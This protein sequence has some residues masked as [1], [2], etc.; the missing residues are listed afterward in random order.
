MVPYECMICKMSCIG[1]ISFIH[2]LNDTQSQE[3]EEF[4]WVLVVEYQ[5]QSGSRIVSD[6]YNRTWLASMALN[7]LADINVINVN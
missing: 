1:A 7:S 2:I 5:L 3:I 4:A 6:S